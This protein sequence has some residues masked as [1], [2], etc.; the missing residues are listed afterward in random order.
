MSINSL[1]SHLKSIRFQPLFLL[2]ITTLFILSSCQA[3]TPTLPTLAATAV[4]AEADLPS[5]E[6]TPTIAPTATETA[7]PLPPPALPTA[8]P[9][10]TPSPTPVAT[11]TPTPTPTPTITPTPTPT[12]TPTPSPT[13]PIPPPPPPIALVP[14]NPTSYLSQFRLIAYYGSP[15]G[16]GL[17]ILGNQPRNQTI[18]MLHGTIASY[19][20]HNTDGRYLMP[21]FHMITTVA[22]PAPGPTGNYISH[23]DINFI[24]DWLVTAN[25]ANAAIII[26]IQ[27]GRAPVIDEVNRIR[28][29]LYYPHVHLGID[30]EFTMNNEQVPGI[31]VGQID[32]AQINEVQ[33]VLNQ[34]ALELGVN[35]VLILH[36]F[37]DSMIT[38]K[39]NIINYPHVELVIDGDGY[40]SPGPKIRNYQQYANEPGFE[41]GGFK[42]F[43]DH[44]DAPVM[45]PYEV[46]N[47]LNPQPVLIIYQ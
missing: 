39:Q 15:L 36:Q 21:T 16:R 3:E 42:L 26:E 29:L 18:R 7:T 20:P 13:P 17:G 28:E 35:R 38:N 24:Y 11:D 9:T 23:V 8:L 41:Y 2:L 1:S 33:A 31:Q 12:L 45:T 6:P 19:N 40:G 10:R 32:A 30:P 34:I 5:P 43:P 47:S 4:V 22:K 27:P 37:K 25:R 44:G 46:M 14:G